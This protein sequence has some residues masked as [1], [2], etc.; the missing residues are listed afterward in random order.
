MES[1]DGWL[2]QNRKLKELVKRSRW[3]QSFCTPLIQHKFQRGDNGTWKYR[4]RTVSPRETLV[5]VAVPVPL[6][7]SDKKEE[8]I[9]CLGDTS[10]EVACCKKKICNSCFS[11]LRD[12]NCPHCRGDLIQSRE[13]Y[14][15]N[16]NKIRMVGMT[17]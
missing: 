13:N 17:Y 12:V 5:Q 1:F 3:I 7:K 10:S 16:R 9:V 15:V 14:L 2:K 6:K 8:C 11:Q 4:M